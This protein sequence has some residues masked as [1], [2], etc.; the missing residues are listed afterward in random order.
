MAA[1]ALSPGSQDPG[2]NYLEQLT[3]KAVD[4]CP[5][6]GSPLLVGTSYT[7]RKAV[8]MR[9]GCGLWSCPVC[10]PRNGKKWLGRTLHAT[11]L[12]GGQWSFVTLTAH[13]KFRG[14]A[15]LTNIRRNWPK[16][17]KRL[18]RAVDGTF[19]YLWVYERH[20]DKS[21]HV[22]MLTNAN[23]DTRWYKD[24]SAECG[25]GYQAKSLPLENYGMAAGYIAKYLLKQFSL[26]PPYPKNMRRITT[27]RN[28]PKRP[29]LDVKEELSWRPLQDKYDVEHYAA[30][31][32]RQ[33]WEV[34]GSRTV[35]RQVDKYAV[36]TDGSPFDKRQST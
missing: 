17:R 22:H 1:V 6:P 12:I 11:N 13:P 16:L 29:P 33:G 28:F 27:S 14:Q 5:N 24:K 9:P 36:E 7:K 23:L 25:L 20:K 32:K 31:L 34:V 8:F 35:V 15:S 4:C 3:A 10:G 26:I 2:L 18:A 21:W 30:M 19:Y